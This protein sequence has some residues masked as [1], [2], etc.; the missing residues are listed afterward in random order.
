[1]THPALDISEKA[2]QALV[3]QAA[4]ATG[5]Y[6][7]HPY[8]SRR[9]EPGYPDLTIVSP[10]RKRTVWIELKTS[11]GKMSPAQKD[12]AWALEQAG[13]EVY[14]LRPADWPLIERILTGADR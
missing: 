7:F 10:T 14:C 4:R 11:K 12:W 3:E 6:V 13:N 9:S 5:W 2:F 1:M 8:D